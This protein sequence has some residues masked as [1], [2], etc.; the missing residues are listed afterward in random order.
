MTNSKKKVEPTSVSSN[1]AKLPVSGA[2]PLAQKLLRS[3]IAADPNV[4]RDYKSSDRVIRSLYD[5]CRRLV[6]KLGGND[7]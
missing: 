5:Q 7:R 2:L 6:K 3:I 1:N 4:E